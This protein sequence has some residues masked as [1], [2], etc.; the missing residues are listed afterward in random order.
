M[1]LSGPSSAPAVVLASASAVRSGL[2]SAAGVPFTTAAAHVD[3]DEV[4]RAF[5]AEGAEAVDAATALAEMKARRIAAA[6]P[7]AL[8]IGADQILTLGPDWFDKPAD[9]DHARAHLRALGGQAHGLATA[10][11]VV[12]DGE[13]IWHHATTPRLVMRPL[14]DSFIDGYLARIGEEALTSVG[15]YQLEGL[16]AQLFARI[17]GDFFTILGLPLL[18][19]LAFLREHRVIPS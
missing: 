5:R 19:L 17:D 9:M 10:A 6:H 8:V 1:S 7:G 12:R 16:G 3:E 11:V 14:S 4:K 18:P 13:R 15:A 2:L